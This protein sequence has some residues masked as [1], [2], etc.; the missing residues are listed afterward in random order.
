MNGTYLRNLVRPATWCGLAWA[1]VA[2]CAGCST[3][4]LTDP[5]G[6]MKR[7]EDREKVPTR[8]VA[9]WTDTIMHQPGRPG[10]RGIGGRIMFYPR[11][12][13]QPVKAN[14]TLTVYAYDDSENAATDAAP[15]RK[16]V[17]L[18][19]Q[20]A[21]RHSTSQLGD[22]YNVW[23][24]WD[25][26]GNVARQL[27]LI[28]RFEPQEGAVVLSDPSRQL[29]PGAA[30]TPAVSTAVRETRVE[31]SAD[32]VQQASYVANQGEAGEAVPPQA[33]AK[34]LETF[35][36]EVPRAVAQRWQQ[37]PPAEPAAT[38]AEQAPAIAAPTQPM[39]AQTVV[40]APTAASASDDA[41]NPPRRLSPP[42]RSGF[43]QRSLGVR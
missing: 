20:F 24:P 15:A 11:E 35:T 34:G 2:A 28:A 32:G 18:P 8:M 22:S 5:V 23:L 36:I 14:G 13:E 16:F 33:P 12:G 17:F 39:V 6:W 30:A 42:E 40:T 27:T 29:L 4:A 31:K 25:E 37:A 10:V 38:R 19:D 1:V 26:V 9:V 3:L 7:D 43:K 21:K 41:P